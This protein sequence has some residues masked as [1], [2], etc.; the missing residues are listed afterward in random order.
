M[1]GRRYQFIR[2]LFIKYSQELFQRAYHLLGDQERAEELLQET[3]VIAT[4]KAAELQ[5]HP[6]P[7]G[8]LHKTLSNLVYKEVRKIHI[9]EYPLGDDI[10]LFTADVDRSNI[11]YLLPQQLTAE[12]KTILLLRYELNYSYQE[13]ANILG[14]SLSACGMRLQRAK[15]RCHDLLIKEKIT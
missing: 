15:K 11:T 1:D 2:S 4:S 14:I 3:F 8:W 9:S 10:E 12:E 5:H 13:I 6:N 7:I